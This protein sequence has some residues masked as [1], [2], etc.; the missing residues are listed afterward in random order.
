[1]SS[2]RLGGRSTPLFVRAGGQVRDHL[3]NQAREGPPGAGGKPL[4]GPETTRRSG[5]GRVGY[6]VSAA[7]A[8]T[9][10]RLVNPRRMAMCRIR[11]R[12]DFTAPGLSGLVD[13]ASDP[14]A[15]GLHGHGARDEVPVGV[16]SARARTSQ[17]KVVRIPITGRRIRARED[18]T[19][20][21]WRR[22]L[23][24]LSDPRARGLH[25]YLLGIA[26]RRFLSVR[27]DSRGII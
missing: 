26:P 17:R 10:L 25:W 4:A 16:R 9:S 27:V 6:E 7:R 3:G 15:R 21:G 24:V 2:I 19:E 14:R 13:Q 11:A 5:V 23:E 20:D 18:F 1:M 22:V 12:E 8:R